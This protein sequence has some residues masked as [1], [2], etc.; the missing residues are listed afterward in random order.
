MLRLVS[1]KIRSGVLKRGSDGGLVQGN[2]HQ[3][4]GAEMT[5]KSVVYPLE[6]LP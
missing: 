1:R 4:L 3:Y 6:Q 5:H 2:T